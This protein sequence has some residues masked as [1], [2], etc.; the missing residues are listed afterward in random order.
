MGDFDADLDDLLEDSVKG[1]EDF[2]SEDVVGGDVDDLLDDI[3]GLPAPNEAIEVTEAEETADEVPVAV[4]VSEEAETQAAAS[5]VSA[6]SEA[7]KDPLAVTQDKENIQTSPPPQKKKPTT[8]K[9]TTT[10]TTTTP[11]TSASST[12]SKKKKKPA[13]PSRPTT[14][15]AT[16]TTTTRTATTPSKPKTPKSSSPSRPKTPTRTRRTPGPKTPKR[17]D[18]D[19]EDET[20]QGP[21]CDNTFQPTLHPKR[22]PCQICV[23][24]LNETEKAKFQTNKRHLGVYITRGGCLDCQAFPSQEG[25]DPVRIGRQCFFDTHKLRPHNPGPF[26]GVTCWA[27]LPIVQPNGKF[28]M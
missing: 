14:T 27:G 7:T 11:S 23:F 3:I 19:D 5:A 22:G 24:K 2:P 1:G 15:T 18:A 26:S 9:A 8:T 6:L 25:E 10:A 16:T 17:E 21:I 28:V 20:P 4:A 12:S 13:T